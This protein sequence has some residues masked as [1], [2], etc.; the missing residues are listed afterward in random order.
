MFMH[1][2][3]WARSP[4]LPRSV[5]FGGSR[6][7]GAGAAFG[8]DE[9]HRPAVCPVRSSGAVH[10]SAAAGGGCLPGPV[11][12]LLPLPRRVRPALL[13]GLVRAT[14]PG[15]AVRAPPAPGAVHPVDAGDPAVQAIDRLAAVL[16]HPPG[17]TGPASSTACWRTYPPNTSA[18]P[19]SRRNRRPWGS[20]TCNSRPCSPRPANHRI[21][22]TSHWW[23]C[24]GCSACGSSK[25]PGPAS[26]TSAKNTATGC[27]GCA[28]KAPSSC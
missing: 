20:P 6:R 24:S 25:P 8:H 26:P 23:P 15:P 17:S 21:R 18:G 5:R 22:P 28:A 9:P 12:G 14:R 7:A 11:Q 3:R 1:R 13:P 19:R 2:Q 16:G 10:W 27:W 4:L